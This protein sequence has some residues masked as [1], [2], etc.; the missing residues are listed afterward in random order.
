MS[1]F[2]L[3]ISIIDE[4]GLK[5]MLLV[6]H[7]NQLLDILINKSTTKLLQIFD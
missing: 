2:F 6:F 1:K 5:F 7:V 3:H 4:F